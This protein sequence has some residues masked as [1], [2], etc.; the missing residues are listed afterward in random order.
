MVILIDTN[1][2]LDVLQGRKPF[3]QKSGEVI[4]LCGERSVKGYMAPH[5]VSNIFFIMRKNCSGEQRRLLLKGLLKII[6]VGGI[7]HESVVEA[8]K[9]EEFSDFEDCLQDECAKG[10]GAD[11]I[12]TRNIKDFEQS[13]VP[14]ITPEQFL[15]IMERNK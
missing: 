14:A 2:L 15:K 6:R 11:Y 4:R 7:N 10:I 5:S 9:R 12:I 3:L 1:V 8:L 13:I